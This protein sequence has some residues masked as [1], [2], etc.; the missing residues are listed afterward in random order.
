MVKEKMAEEEIEETHEDLGKR[1]Y[2]ESARKLREAGPSVFVSIGVAVLIWIIGKLVFIPI[3]QGVEFFGYPVIQIVDF[4]ILVALIFLVLRV[5]IDIR[6]LA[7]GA[8]GILAFEFGKARGE[9]RTE[10]FNNYKAMLSGVLY[11]VVVSVAYL[12][13]ADYLALLH[14]ALAGIVL[15]VI[16]VWAVLALW[17]AGRGISREV[18]RSTD[19]WAEDLE[20]RVKES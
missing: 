6:G 17:R 3:S 11:V 18:K 19:K 15:V 1:A 2:I 20:K 4:V 16:V 5:F 14:P 8:A 10:S 12:I 13:F 7:E 9:V